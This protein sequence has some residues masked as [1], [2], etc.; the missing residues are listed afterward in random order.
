[1]SNKIPTAEEFYKLKYPDLSPEE[2]M[3]EFAKLHVREAIRS[4]LMGWF[5]EADLNTATEQHL[6][7]FYPIEKVK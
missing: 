4:V 6:K 7:F 1:M 5:D 3:I 2:A